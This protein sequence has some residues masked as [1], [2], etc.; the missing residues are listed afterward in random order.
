MP[1][2]VPLYPLLCVL[3]LPLIFFFQRIEMNIFI[4]EWEN[5]WHYPPDTV[6]Y[7]P[8]AHSTKSSVVA[9][10]PYWPAP[11][12]KIASWT[13]TGNWGLFNC[14]RTQGYSGCD[15]Q[16]AWKPQDWCAACDKTCQRC[17]QG[18]T[19]PKVEA[20][21]PGQFFC[22]LQGI[23]CAD[24]HLQAQWANNIHTTE[25]Q[26]WKWAEGADH[27]MRQK[28]IRDQCVGFFKYLWT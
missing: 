27:L 25:P 15:Q 24:P 11:F 28:V 6:L 19:A 9:A 3:L 26:D 2:G 8:H 18:P 23:E 16:C 7:H 17:P 4:V 10:F 22:R 5:H 20:V 14:L 13:G 1:Y 21:E 12:R